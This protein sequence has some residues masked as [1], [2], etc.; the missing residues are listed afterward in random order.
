VKSCWS[1]QLLVDSGFWRVVVETIF[2]TNVLSDTEDQKW[3]CLFHVFNLVPILD[4][5]CGALQLT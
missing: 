5:F 4:G 2:C 1:R 3:C